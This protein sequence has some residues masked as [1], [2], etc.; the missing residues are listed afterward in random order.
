MQS[1]LLVHLVHKMWSGACQ[2]GAL[3]INLLAKSQWLF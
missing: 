1:C 2:K 3:L